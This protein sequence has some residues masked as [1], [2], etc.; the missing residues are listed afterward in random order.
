MWRGFACHYLAVWFV[1]CNVAWLCVPLPGCVVCV[2][3]GYGSRAMELLQQYYEG[4]MASIDDAESDTAEVDSHYGLG[5]CVCVCV[6]EH[7]CGA[8]V[9]LGEGV[10]VCAYA[11]GACV[12]LRVCVCICLC[13]CTHAYGACVGLGVCVHVFWFVCVCVNVWGWCMLC[14]CVYGMRV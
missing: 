10:C 14:V 7:A 2:Q 6:C 12:G 11:C 4:K 9:G 5:V 13:V 8:C 1:R 3:M